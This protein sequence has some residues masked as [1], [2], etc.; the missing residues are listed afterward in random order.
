MTVPVELSSSATCSSLTVRASQ[1]V[2]PKSCSAPLYYGLTRQ[3]HMD[4]TTH[5]QACSAHQRCA[6]PQGRVSAT[7]HKSL[8]RKRC[9]HSLMLYSIVEQIFLESAYRVTRTPPSRG[10]CTSRLQGL[11]GRTSVTW[12]RCMQ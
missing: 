10:L 6:P 2:Q 1:Q 8:S 9:R 11:D 5:A 3:D 12:A 4:T 7:I